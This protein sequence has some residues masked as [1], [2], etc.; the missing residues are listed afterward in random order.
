MVTVVMLLVVIA[1]ALTIAAAIGKCPI[2][3][4]VLLLTLVSLLQVMP[5]R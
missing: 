1:F 5:L 4:P 2:W 3:I